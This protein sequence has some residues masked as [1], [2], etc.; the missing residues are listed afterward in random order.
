MFKLVKRLSNIKLNCSYI[1]III[2]IEKLFK[3]C[4]ITH[5]QMN[6]IRDDLNFCISSKDRLHLS[7]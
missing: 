5:M 6:L 4:K 2:T 7:F 3:W 1:I